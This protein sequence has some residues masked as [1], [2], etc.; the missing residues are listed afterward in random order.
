MRASAVPVE[1]HLLALLPQP[2]FADAWSLP[3]AAA[4]DARQAALA[5]FNAPPAWVSALMALRNAIMR[6]FKVKTD[7]QRLPA[8]RG[9]IG[10]FPVLEETPREMLLGLD[11]R[12]L[13]FRL[14]VSVGP[15]AAGARSLT[16]TTVV[17]THNR[18]G[19]LYLAAIL[20]FHRLIAR[21]L[22]ARGAHRL[23]RL[24]PQA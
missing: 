9:R 19:R 16:V 11:D 1:P 15:A 12:H 7:L 22:L 21:R 3:C 8:A 24:P 20:P 18:L 23:E 2:V 14:S 10:M 6:P 5:I 13:D 17:H 4:P